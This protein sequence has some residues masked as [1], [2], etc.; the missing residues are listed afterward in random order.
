[1]PRD[2]AS[3]IHLTS[4]RL[5]FAMRIVSHSPTS[6]A[7]PVDFKRHHYR[8]LEGTCRLGWWRSSSIPMRKRKIECN[9]KCRNWLEF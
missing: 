1:M 7:S 8:F 2:G 3:S 5:R 6:I 9:I 4:R